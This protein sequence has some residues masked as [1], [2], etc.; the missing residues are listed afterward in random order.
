[1]Q[2]NHN[3]IKHILIVDDEQDVIDL[4]RFCLRMYDYNVCTFTNSSIALE[5]FK[6]NPKNHHMVIY[7]ISMLSMNGYEFVKQVKS[8]NPK[9]KVV[10]MTSFEMLDNEFSNILPDVTM[11]GFITKPFTPNLL[12]NI[13]VS[14][15]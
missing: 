2:L 11:D 5:H 14:A 7:D 13:I 8:M 1:M 12:R 4:I 3:N 10:L 9:V 15:K 6:S